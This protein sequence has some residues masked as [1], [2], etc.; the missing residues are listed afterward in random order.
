MKLYYSPGACSLAP[1]VALREIGA[2]FELARVRV[3]ERENFS[4]DYLRVNPRARVPAL[5]RGGAI[6]TEA[7]ALLVFIAS[8]APEA[9]LLPPAGSGELARALEWLAWFNS[10]LHIAYAQFWRPGRFLP[11]GSDTT[12]LVGQGRKTIERMNKEVEER[13]AGPW[14]LGERYSLADVYAL[15]FFRWGNRIGL[16]MAEANPRWAVWTDRMLT[17]PAVRAALAAEGLAEEEFLPS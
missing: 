16:A 9:N 2:D 5:E 10:S 13:L 8:L 6:Y 12:E 15:P 4:P 1:H 11:E 3:A 7:P 14:L 17:R